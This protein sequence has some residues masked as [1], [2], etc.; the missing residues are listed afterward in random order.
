[1]LIQKKQFLMLKEANYSPNHVFLDIQDDIHSMYLSDFVDKCLTCWREIKKNTVVMVCNGKYFK[2]CLTLITSFYKH[3]ENDIN[4]THVFYLGL[5]KEEQHIL[6]NLKKL[7]F[8]PMIEIL[9]YT[10]ETR[11]RFAEILT[12]NQFAYKPWFIF[13]NI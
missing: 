4:V 1:M 9:D 10:S 3:S 6:L 5:T 12:P 13:L 7:E 8:K 11:V 2:A